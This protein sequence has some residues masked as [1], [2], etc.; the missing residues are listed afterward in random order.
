[1][2]FYHEFHRIQQ[3][4]K[5]IVAKFDRK[6]KKA[7][8][9]IF[10]RDIFIYANDPGAS[11]GEAKNHSNKNEVYPSIV[12]LIDHIESLANIANE[13]HK[14]HYCME[15]KNELNTIK[16]DC[17]NKVTRL[18]LN[19]FSLY[20]HEALNKDDF[21][22]LIEAIYA[23]AKQQQP[24][25]HLLLSSIPVL[26]AGKE[27]LNM[28]FYVQCGDEPKIETFCKAT[29]SSTDITCK[30]V[31]F[32]Q[33]P[34]AYQPASISQFASHH[35]NTI[36]SN[37]TIF[38]ITTKGGAQYTQA[39]DIC[40]DHHYKHSKMLVKDII[41]K[42]TTTAVVPDKVD[43]ILTSNYIEI[44][45]NSMVSTNIVHID[46][47]C[48]RRL[49]SHISDDKISTVN[50]QAAKKNKYPQ[51]SI[52]KMKGGFLVENPPFGSNYIVNAR[53][54]R[55]LEGFSSDLKPLVNQ[56]NEAVKN[57]AVDSYLMAANLN[58]V[59]YN[60]CINKSC[61]P[62]DKL[63]NLYDYLLKKSKPTFLEILFK[64]T[65]CN[66]KHTIRNILKN[67]R[68]IMF[69][70]NKDPA[71]L[72]HHIDVLLDDLKLQVEHVDYGMKSSFI[73]NLSSEIDK[74]HRVSNDN[75]VS[76]LLPGVLHR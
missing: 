36:I 12:R 5:K 75:Q 34:S 57:H 67:S 23:I 47:V 49:V 11:Y 29:C 71:N 27:I 31:P 60:A 10:I 8:Q 30:R 20:S 7:N 45:K 3:L 44:E 73:R 40:L 51:M 24:N 1:M 43:H 21:T 38:P 74:A 50:L 69:S 55:K 65:I 72:I 28:S 53:E 6:A 13:Y 25:V 32:S 19:E 52:K 76:L 16:A 62:F 22:L 58:M 54:E 42:T 46:P 56:Y 35:G 63:C 68:Q 18:S 26:S 14:S 48:T 17:L 41:G 9:N 33:Q 70:L 4:R 39:V 15:N 2:N 59:K 61:E 64:S 66:T 37:N